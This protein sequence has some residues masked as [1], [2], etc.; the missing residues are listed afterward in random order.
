MF[1][2]RNVFQTH[3]GKA[4]EL[5]AKF[6]AASPH[7]QSEGVRNTRI[8]TDVAAGFWTVVIESETDDLGAFV[9]AV[10]TMGEKPEL[11]AAMAGY[12]DLVQEGRREIFRVE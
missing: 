7:M 11:R 6:K 1:V 4:K 9:R 12:M 8:L 10:E 2:V 3:P 5:V